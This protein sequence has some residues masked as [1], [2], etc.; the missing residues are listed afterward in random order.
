MKGAVPV[1]LA[2]FGLQ[3]LGD[4]HDGAVVLV[5]LAAVCGHIWPLY[6][7][8]KGGK[9][10]A[11]AFGV[12]LA[13]CPLAAI[14]LTALYGVVFQVWRISSV[15]SLAAAWAMPVAVG[16]FS[17]L[18]AYLLLSAVL[19]G[20]ILWRHQENVIRLCRRE[21]PEL[22]PGDLHIEGHEPAR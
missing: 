18:K 12:I 10:V 20:L 4:W 8:F 9:A 13:I 2:R 5:G 6:L 1:F 14:V 21:E 16:L 7:N 19:S 3:G 17:N 22:E 15:A 11:T